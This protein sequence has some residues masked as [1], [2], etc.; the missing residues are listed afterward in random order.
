MKPQF[1]ERQGAKTLRGE[2]NMRKGRI[3]IGV[4]LVC[5][6]LLAPAVSYGQSYDKLSKAIAKL[7]STLRVII[8]KQKMEQPTGQ[9]IADAEGVTAAIP[10]PVNDVSGIYELASDLEGVVTQLQG[11]VTEAK[12]A[13]KGRPQN[14]LSSGHGKISF[15]GVFHEQYYTR[16][17]EPRTSSFDTRYALLGVSGVI[18]EWAKATFWGSFAK[19]PTLLDAYASVMPNK[20]WTVNFGQYKPPFGTDF[21]KAASGMFFVNNFK[22]QSLGTGRDVG[23]DITLN[24]QWKNGNA[25]K[26]AGGMYNGAPSNTSDVNND[27]NFI[28]RAE[29]RLAKMFMIAPNL[30][31]GKTNDPDST[32]KNLDVWGGSVNWSWRN[33]IIEGEYIHNQTG[34]VE[35]QGWH[36]WGAHT[37]STGL[38][39]VPELQMLARYEQID[40]DLDKAGDR[41]DRITL[42]TNLYVD[43]KFTKLQ[44]NYQING[45]ETSSVDNNEWLVLLQLAF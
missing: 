7:D 13:E 35:K 44:I 33:E 23:A 32:K 2:V 29:I 43:K 5:L 24:Y 10:R 26:V 12:E 3:V 37:F 36:V 28:G 30:I 15:G 17:G 20:Y 41:T 45:E 1:Q 11:V 19:T 8:D 34:S 22:G 6:L 9:Q 4:S 25:I 14:P 16:E 39:F 21:L 42:G 40:P 31:A 38:K 27:K 18:N